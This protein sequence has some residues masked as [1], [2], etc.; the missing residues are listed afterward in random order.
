MTAVRFA[1]YLNSERSLESLYEGKKSGLVSH[2][3]FRKSKGK[4]KLCKD[5]GCSQGGTHNA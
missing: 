3:H 1:Y 4:S 2:A 5:K